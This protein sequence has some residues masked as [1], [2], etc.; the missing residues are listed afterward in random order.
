MSQRLQIF[1]NTVRGYGNKR[2][3]THLKGTWSSNQSKWHC[4]NTQPHCSATSSPTEKTN[5]DSPPQKRQTAVTDPKKKIHPLNVVTVPKREIRSPEQS[6]PRKSF[7]GGPDDH[8]ADGPLEEIAPVIRVVDKLPQQ[9]SQFLCTIDEDYVDV[10][11]GRPNDR[12]P[13][14]KG[15]EGNKTLEFPMSQIEAHPRLGKLS[16]KQTDV[17]GN[18]GLSI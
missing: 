16:C 10:H 5:L 17:L 14:K 1:E 12:T 3:P 11:P 4:D 15:I 13:Q 8:F 7:S 18:G 6:T 9:Q 2:A